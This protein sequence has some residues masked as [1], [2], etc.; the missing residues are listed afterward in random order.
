M[1]N[2]DEIIKQ[3]ED[4][5]LGKKNF[6]GKHVVDEMKVTNLLSRLRDSVPQAFYEAQTLLRQQEALIADAERRA[7]SIIRNA[8]EQRD[9]MIAESEIL[10][11]AQRQAEELKAKTERYCDDLTASLH[12]KLD[13]EL[14]DVA[15]KMNDAMIMV[16]DLRDELARRAAPPMGENPAG[17]NGGGEDQ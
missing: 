13:R 17:G 11:E 12:R 3:L 2:V 7:E 8:A 15:Y 6:F 5:L 16:E 9:K 14:Y 10:A 4:E 1:T